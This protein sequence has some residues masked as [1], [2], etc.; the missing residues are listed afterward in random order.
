MDEFTWAYME[1]ALWS[2]NDESDESGGEPLDANY[3]IDDIA[4]ETRSQ[5]INDARSFQQMHAELIEIDDSPAIREHGRWSLAGHDFWLTRNGHGSGFWDGDWPKS[6][7]ALTK[8]AEGFGAYDLYVGDDGLIYGSGGL[9]GLREERTRAGWRTTK[10][11]IIQ[12][13][14]GYF[15]VLMTQDG[16]T[17]ISRK[18]H[19]E[20]RG[21]HHEKKQLEKHSLSF[22]VN[23]AIGF[24][25]YEAA[26]PKRTSRSPQRR[27]AMSRRGE[28]RRPTRKQRRR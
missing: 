15:R 23:P 25:P 11:K 24:D 18:R 16:R 8:A 22:V 14:D 3:T 10:F 6:G 4:P 12:T 26:E 2:T 7:D 27:H 28:A 13:P 21:A 17:F 19:G 9:S 5:M 1:A 20:R